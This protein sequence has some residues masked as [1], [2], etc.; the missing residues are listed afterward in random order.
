MCTKKLKDNGNHAIASVYVLNK[1]TSSDDPAVIASKHPIVGTFAY[2]LFDS[3][4]FYSFI[5]VSMVR[6]THLLK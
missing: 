1:S 2:T 4:S 5:F 6:M 3:L